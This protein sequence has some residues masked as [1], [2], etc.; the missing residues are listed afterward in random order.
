MPDPRTIN[1]NLGREI[2]ALLK[3]MTER[4]PKD[5]YQTVEELIKDLS[6]A[7]LAEDPHSSENASLEE[8]AILSALKIERFLS[9]KYSEEVAELKE[10]FA[11]FRLYFFLA[12]GLVALSVA[13]NIYL[14]FKILG[15]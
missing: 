11:N 7:R 4:D 6:T 2:C 1:P 10:K 14:F 12:L 8:S 9:E 13:L 3:K 15:R 5:R